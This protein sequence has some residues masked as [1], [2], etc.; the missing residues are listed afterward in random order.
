MLVDFFTKPL[1]GSL[2]ERFRKIIDVLLQDSPFPIKECVDNHSI[3]QVVSYN[4]VETNG[5]EKY[6][7]ATKS[8]TNRQKTYADV[9]KHRQIYGRLALTSQHCRAKEQE[10]HA[11]YENRGMTKK[12]NR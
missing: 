12:G 3:C 10:I 7:R 8:Q 2:H 5:K 6:T 9:T 1:P 4:S 11:D